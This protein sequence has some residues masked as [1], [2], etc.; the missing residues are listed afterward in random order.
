MET[1]EPRVKNKR[2]GRPTNGPLESLKVKLWF[3]AVAGRV[4]ATTGYALEKYFSP[5]TVKPGPNGG[6]IRSC[7]FD[8]YKRGEHVP[9]PALVDRIE[10][11]FPG[12]KLFLEHPF[13]TIAKTPLTDIEEFYIQLSNLRPE[14]SE[15]LFFSPINRGRMPVRRMTGPYGTIE[16]LIKESDWDALTACIGL[17]QEAKYLYSNEP[18]YLQHCL[19]RYTRRTLGVFLPAIS[20]Q[21]FPRIAHELFSY[22]RENFLNRPQDEA[23]IRKLDSTNLDGHIYVYQSMLLIIEDLDIFKHYYFAPHSCLHLAESHLNGALI[24]KIQRLFMS[25][26]FHEVPKLPE[27]KNLTRCLRRWEKKRIAEG[28]T[29]KFSGQ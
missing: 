15:L 7:R 25:G 28:H 10:S 14:I 13:W 19:E 18:G 3:W 4:G 29:D 24:L 16:D 23:W 21:P 2:R 26:N 1:T 17:I 27:I 8:K 12:T 20:Q 11:E 6:T 5:E 22:L 9:D